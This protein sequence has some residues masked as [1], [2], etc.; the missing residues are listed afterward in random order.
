MEYESYHFTLVLM[1]YSTDYSSA[2]TLVLFTLYPLGDRE[3]LVGD[4]SLLKKKDKSELFS[5]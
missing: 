2:F 4:T 5:T 3:R 1:N